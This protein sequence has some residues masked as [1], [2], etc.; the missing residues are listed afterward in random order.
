MLVE[1][2]ADALSPD[3]LARIARAL[4][5][6][7]DPH[8][9]RIARASLRSGSGDAAG[10]ALARLRIEL[11]P[12]GVL[13]ITARAVRSL[14]A[15]RRAI[16]RAPSA[17]ARRIALEQHHLLELMTSASEWAPPG[18]RWALSA[19]DGGRRPAGAPRRAGRP[20]AWPR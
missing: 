7:L 6:A 9:R 20:M 17:V 5:L 4:A 16:R 15:A 13:T 8:Q 3:E 18:G 1:A 2:E 19:A 10:G 11:R 12:A 14:S